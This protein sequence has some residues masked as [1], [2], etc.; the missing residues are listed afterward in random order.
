M[1]SAFE[2]ESEMTITLEVSHPALTEF[3]VIVVP[4]PD[5]A[6]GKEYLYVLTYISLVNVCYFSSSEIIK[7]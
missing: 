6:D 4:S 5:I 1:F 2:N 7:C 3:T